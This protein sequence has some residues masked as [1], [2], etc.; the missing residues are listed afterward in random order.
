MEIPLFLYML[1]SYLKYP[2]FQNLMY[3]KSC[4]VRYSEVRIFSKCSNVTAYYNDKSIQADANHF[5]FLSS[6][7]L[8]LPSFFSTLLLGAA[9]DL[10]SVK[11]PLL[12]P[13][14]GLILCTSN[15]VMQTVYMDAS[16]YLLLI[17]DAIFG[18]CGGYIAILATVISYGVKTTSVPRR[19]VRIA[20]VEGAIGLG[21]TAGYILSGTTREILGY[22]YVFLLMLIL[23]VVAFF[24][25]LIF[26]K[27]CKRTGIDRQDNEVLILE[28]TSKLFWKCVEA[29]SN[30]RQLLTISRRFQFILGLNLLAFGVE[31]FIFSGLM[32]IQYSYL[33][34]KLGWGDQQY[35]WFSGLTVYFANWQTLISVLYPLLYLRGFTDGTLGCFGL[36]AKMLS[37]VLLA[38]LTNSAMA[39]SLIV[40]TCLNRF[41]PT[42]FRSF[43]SSIIE[44]TEQGKM[45]SLIALLE[46]AIGLLASAFF[47]TLYPKTLSFFP[48][49][50]YIAS[51]LVLGLVAAQIAVVADFAVAFARKKVSSLVDLDQLAY[52]F[53][54]GQNDCEETLN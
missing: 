44:T 46:G 37:L 36:L 17:S 40:V 1:T 27:E 9:T 33:Q 29:L 35:G 23:Q 8:T 4:L 39:Y 48:G 38:F 41:I 28:R 13:F 52:S 50:F 49:L 34:F 53:Q 3:E 45:F 14:F 2:V 26:A 42:G 21:G 22:P 54:M 31:L 7:V 6:V 43:I 47:N 32:D 25:I 12:I 16:I 24:Y 5:Y 30:Y 19:S 20:G 51:C 11:V 15:Y 10:W 18:I